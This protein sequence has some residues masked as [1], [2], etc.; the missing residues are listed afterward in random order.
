MFGTIVYVSNPHLRL[1][2]LDLYCADDKDAGHKRKAAD[3]DDAPTA[4]HNKA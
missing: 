1:R 4:K 3:A 2:W